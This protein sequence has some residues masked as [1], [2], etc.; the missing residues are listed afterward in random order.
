[1]R[2]S[3]WYF[4]IH[5][6]VQNLCQWIVKLPPLACD[7][8]CENTA[9]HF[10]H[11]IIKLYRNITIKCK[12]T[13]LLLCPVS[14]FGQEQK[15]QIPSPP[16]ENTIEFT[17]VGCGLVTKFASHKIAPDCLSDALN[18]VFDQDVGVQRRQGYGQFNVT[19][20]TGAQPVRRL[21]D[22]DASDGS[23]YVMAVSSDK[24]YSAGT[25]GVFSA[26][27]GF[28]GLSATLN[29]S[30]VQGLGA[31]WCVNQS[32]GLI[33]WNGTSTATVSAGP[34]GS[35]IDV[36]RNRIIIADVSGNQSR[37]YG[38]GHLD[39]TNWTTAAASTS[40]FIISIGGT[41]DG[42]K[43]KC[44]MGTYSDAY[45]LGTEQ[46]LYALYGFDNNDFAVRE[47]SREVGCLDQTSVQEMDGALYWLSRRGI[48][49]MRGT[50]I[51]WKVSY[52][53][54]DI[55]QE[56]IDAAGN[57]RSVTDTLQAD[58]QAGNLTASGPGAPMSATIS[59][60]S[61]VPSTWTGIDT[62]STN[63]A[64]GTF[65]TST[66]TIGELTINEALDNSGFSSDVSG[67]TCD[68]S[69]SQIANWTCAVASGDNF[70]VASPSLP[71]FDCPSQTLVGGNDVRAGN[72][73]GDNTT[74]SLK[75]DVLNAA[76]D[77]VLF[78]RT[79]TGTTDNCTN[80]SFDTSTQ[81]VANL[82][83]RVTFTDTATILTSASFPRTGTVPYAFIARNNTPSTSHNIRFDMPEPF[84]AFSGTF[85]SRA[86]DT[87]FS[88]PTWGV[89]RA[90]TT[91]PTGSRGTISFT[92]QV[93]TKSADTFDTAVAATIESK[94]TSA[95]KRYIRYNTVLTTLVSTMTPSIQDVELSAA[96][97]GY[98]ISQCRNP[99][100]AITSWGLFACNK[101]D[102]AG[103]FTFAIA[104][105]A[106]CGASTASTATWN[107]QTNNATISVA[108][109]PYVAY[110]VLF[111][112]DSGTETPTL[113]DCTINWEEGSDRPE[114]ASGVHDH[115]YHLFY[116]TSTASSPSNTSAL[117]LDQFDRWSLWDNIP[118]RSS[119]R[120]RQD[121]L[122]GDGASTGKIYRLYTGNDDDGSSFTS[123]IRTRDFDADNW[124]AEK[125]FGPLYLEVSP[126]EDAA[127]DV[128]LTISA[129]I[130]VANK[131]GLGTINLAEDSGVIA[132]RVPW[133]LD[134]Q[135]SGRYISIEI[136]N[137]GTAP[138]RFYRGA[139]RNRVLREE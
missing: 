134:T 136:S 43:I 60:G 53:I 106:T 120:F 94:I 117:V 29:T 107:A 39:G 75:V 103:D 90:T 85:T 54:I 61:V 115:R 13:L 80:Q 68:V 138:W 37:L 15:N 70:V 99:G 2:L 27:T 122:I 114:V 78:T 41:N 55:I 100:T 58:F 123:R 83:V 87:S 5:F 63:F 121:L 1:M 71:L 38:S 110:R 64:D 128:N 66:S 47:I 116:T 16:Q 133:S 132:A 4:I 26:V 88:T 139:L 40:P 72:F 77:A 82:K 51:D 135:N 127:D 76:D 24:I 124:R 48:E 98:F 3:L 18:I 7:T 96:T 137:T 119:S 21:Y 42:D 11:F 44:L 52:P 86:F 131:Y 46:R 109:V 33:N 57:S 30:C 35:L 65:T 84:Y 8:V 6:L 50:S 112:I 104:T 111:N 73:T 125:V 81:T 126:E 118:A 25:D 102:N 17:T 12:L 32:N 89:F 67:D 23:Q 59:A 105:G 108:T 28:T 10:L 113:Q 69:L 19:A 93:S 14:A 56:I 62:S 92:T 34:L 45:I 97:T 36:F 9:P 74:A 22:F 95:S 31:F 130:D 91:I 129:Y 101:I 79:H 20:L 49:R